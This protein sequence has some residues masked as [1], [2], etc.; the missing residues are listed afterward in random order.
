MIVMKKNILKYTLHGVFLLSILAGCKKNNFVVDKSPLILP[1][2]ARFVMTPT[3]AD[4]YYLYFIQQN[5]V[6]G[7]TFTVPIGVTNLSGSDRKVKLTY[8]SPRA[9]SGVQYTGPPEV[10]IPANLAK[11]NLIFQGLFA[12]YPTGRK[13]T[14]KI[15]LTSGDGF[16][17]PAAY[18]DSVMLI[19]QKYCDVVLAGLGGNYT[20]NEYYA[21]GAY[22]Y[23][24]YA[25]GV[26]NLTSTG[27]TT[28]SGAFVNLFDYGWN[29]INFTMD[30]TDPANFKVTIPLQTTGATNAGGNYSYVRSTA[31]KT[32]TFSSCDQTFS[33]SLDLMFNPTT[34]DNTLPAYQIRLKR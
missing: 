8:S 5:P 20:A 3:T 17:K 7:S 25:S 10:T 28:A 34:V 30:W 32:N 2:A 11:A 15:K 4:N 14:V 33:I 16:I 23:G 31:G 13:D 1:E 9:V 24:P 18:Q 19:L 26:V 27:A 22:S 12:G 29:N 21:S 6:P